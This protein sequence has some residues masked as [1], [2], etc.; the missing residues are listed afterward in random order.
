MRP[1]GARVL[2]VRTG[3]RL[4]VGTVRGRLLTGFGATLL[5]M[6]VGQV[7]VA[8]QL[9]RVGAGAHRA[10]AGLR[11]EYAAVDG[12]VT[13]VL[14]QSA[15]G[16]RFVYGGRAAD[17][18]AYAAASGEAHRLRRHALA[19]AALSPAERGELE[20]LEQLQA[21]I[22]VGVGVA[23]AYRR[24]GRP[25]DAERVF[26]ARAGDVAAVER[27]VR[28]L[29]RAADARAAGHAREATAAVARGEAWILAGLGVALLG[30]LLTSRSTS[31]AVLRPLDRLARAV[32]TLGAGDFA[33]FDRAARRVD[34]GA[35]EFAS[36]AAALVRARDQITAARRDQDRALSLLH[37]TLDATADGIVV[38][39]LDGRITGHNRTFLAL[40]GVAPGVAG[41]AAALHAAVRAAAA[42]HLGDA[43]ALFGAFGGRE[44]GAWKAG[45]WEAEAG[46]TGPD[47]LRL[48]DGRVIERHA[49]AQRLAGVTVGHVFSF[50]DVT[51]REAL[52]ARLAHEASHD[53][54]TGLANR[55]RF[56]ARAERALRAAAAAGAPGRVAV[57]LLDLDGFKAV[58]DTLGHAAGD[59]LLRVV[60]ERLLDATRGSD[61][62][63]R[64]GGDEFAVLMGAVRGEADV[65]TVA[66]RVVAA[67]RAPVV[68]AVAPGVVA[69]GGG[70]G[71]G[72]ARPVTATV[73]ASVGIACAD[74]ASGGP[75]ATLAADAVDTLLARAD[76]AMYRAK[77]GGPGR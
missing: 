54:L 4:V 37:A 21:Q 50:R 20:Q 57:L 51:E 53:P 16:A 69:G 55:A 47:V 2:A 44:A 76:A 39:G 7:L 29:R 26:D 35:G 9:H 14:L 6:L 40:W 32:S 36:L 22:E 48:A 10:V 43:G 60:A 38:V 61:T 12:V 5:L 72:G 56:H 65:V 49:E 63:A 52:E 13:A 3:A 23:A 62:V 8:A 70:S 31:R 73:G 45:A 30:A 15:A 42:A 59:D 75:A 41:D 58:N 1:T 77:R 68:L 46:G 64:L 11:A 19:L 18:A 25:A 17:S 67:V 24:V 33:A 66:E 71:E 27:G 28:A 74:A 34:V